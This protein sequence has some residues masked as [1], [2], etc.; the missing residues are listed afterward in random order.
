MA[1]LRINSATHRH[2]KCSM[3][4]GITASWPQRE[5][6][7]RPAGILRTPSALAGKPPKLRQPLTLLSVHHLQTVHTNICWDRGHLCIADLLF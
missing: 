2:V 5:A 1:A 6:L 7:G 3:L 4:R